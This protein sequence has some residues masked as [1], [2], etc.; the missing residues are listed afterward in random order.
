MKFIKK[1]FNKD[2]TQKEFQDILD[3]QE[4]D[5]IQLEDMYVELMRKN[6]DLEKKIEFYQEQLKIV[7]GIK[8]EEK[9]K[10]NLW[11]WMAGVGAAFGALL[12]SWLTKDDKD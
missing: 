12:G 7:E 9:S 3:I 8:V 5:I 4:K 1:I 2:L 11:K 10:V 6:K